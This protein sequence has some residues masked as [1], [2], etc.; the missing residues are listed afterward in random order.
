MAK[1]NQ[2]A[3]LAKQDANIEAGFAELIKT[4]DQIADGS[5][6]RMPLL[7]SSMRHSIQ[8][9]KLYREVFYVAKDKRGK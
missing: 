3:K 1:S 6:Q 9:V 5:E 7:A 4:F 8:I 2:K